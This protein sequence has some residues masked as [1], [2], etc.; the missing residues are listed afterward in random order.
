M[1]KPL[2]IMHR[3]SSGEIN[4]PDHDAGDDLDGVERAL[5]EFGA[6]K[7][8]TVGNPLEE[9]RLYRLGPIDIALTWDGFTADLQVVGEGDLQ[10]LFA[11]MSA[12][13]LFEVYQTAGQPKV[14]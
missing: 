2:R 11:A 7:L 5:L 1:S 10:A 8:Q 9:M 4:L 14:R 3:D 12:S 13:H 6:E